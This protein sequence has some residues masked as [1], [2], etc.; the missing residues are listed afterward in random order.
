[1]IEEFDWS[2]L[3]L[4]EPFWLIL[5]LMIPFLAWLHSKGKVRK[6]SIQYPSLAKIRQTKSFGPKHFHRLPRIL[7]SFSIILV[8]L[9]LSRP[10][11]DQS[12]E[13]IR[14]SGVDIVLAI[15]LSASM[16][17]LDMS[18]D[19]KGEVTRLDIVKEV[20]KEF[21][22]K[23]NH[24]RL[25]L[26]A[27]SVNPYLVSA[28]TLDKEYLHRNL[29]RL[30]VGLTHQTGTNIGSALAEGINRLRPL[31]SKSKILILLT[32]GKD[33][34]TPPHS[35]L[36]Y[37]DGALKDNIKIYTIAIGTN[38]RTRTYLFDPS[39]RDLM[40]YANGN[41]VVQVADYPVDKEIL[42]RISE[43]TQALF[44]EAKNKSSL[45][46]IY[47]EIDRL[48]KTEVELNVNALFLDLYQWPLGLAAIFLLIEIL[49]SRTVL[50][51]IP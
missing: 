41:P 13:T 39:S 7:R 27:F 12:T 11:L 42:K 4:A 16:L 32:D 49:L 43:K 50:L 9:A 3:H 2:E 24:D 21:I 17:A 31:E 44:F 22:D 15:D 30:K 45:S 38:R 18:E 33:E 36:I 10:Q 8:V 14:S 35:P 25:G 46:S 19:G 26:V 40:R 34:P 48:E 28:L 37:A 23:R 47:S 1:M 6:P 20:I 5:L 29:D 51:R